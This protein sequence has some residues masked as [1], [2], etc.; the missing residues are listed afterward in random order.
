MAIKG[1]GKT[2]TRQVARAPRRG[3][4]EVKPPFLLRRWVQV[5]GACVAGALIVMLVIWVT[6]GLRA[7]RAKSDATAQAGAQRAAGLKW[8]TEVEQ[9][10]GNAGGTVTPGSPAPPT[11]FV[12]VSDAI[13]GIQ[14]GQAPSGAGDALKKAQDQ[15]KAASHA[16]TTFALSDTVRSKGFDVGTVNYFLNSQQLMAQS[17][18]LYRQAAAIA[19]VAL[20]AQGAQQKLLAKHA[21]DLKASADQLF[22]QGW[23]DY[24]QALY[25][26]HL[27]QTP[28]GAPG[29]LPA[30]S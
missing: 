21:A 2:R 30:G 3:P 8:K 16:L 6:N 11:V 26:A 29:G 19:A 14:K 28:L 18:E 22:Q 4:V 23:S 12:P 5:V 9:Q 1:K 15:A 13:T 17:F 24:Q 7:D 25:A 20:D 27:V 10:I